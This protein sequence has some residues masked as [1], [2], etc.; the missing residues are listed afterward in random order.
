MHGLDV[1]LEPDGPLCKW[2]NL[3]NNSLTFFKANTSLSRD[4]WV[5][6]ESCI[7]G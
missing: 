7:N 2:I 4:E 6:L 5:W 3:D 1:Q